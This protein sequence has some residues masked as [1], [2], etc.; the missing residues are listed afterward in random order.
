[1]KTADEMRQKIIDKAAADENFRSQ[2]LSDPKNA[3]QGELD[4]EI[5]DSLE[6]HVHEDDGQTA[7]LILPPNPKLT[8][9]QL[10]SVAGAGKGDTRYFWCI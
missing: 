10:A 4:V 3:I 8:E 2:L 1:M 5:P 6:I 9:T 7:H